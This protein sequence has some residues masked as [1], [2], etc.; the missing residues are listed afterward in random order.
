MNIKLLDAVKDFLL[1]KNK[2]KKRAFAI[3]MFLFVLT[4]AGA[5]FLLMEGR[6][7]G[8]PIPKKEYAQVFTLTSDKIS[9]NAGIAINL[10]PN[11]KVLKEE[12]Q[13][14]VEIIPEIKG[15]WIESGFPD[16]ILFKPDAQMK[17]GR[18][19]SVLMKIDGKTIGSD[20]LVVDDPK[21]LTVFPKK[22][23][24]IHENSEITVMFNRPMVPITTLDILESFDI[25]I[26]I[27]P[28]TIGKFKWIGTRTIQFI[29]KER[30]I[31]SSNYTVK[32]KPEFS[33]LDGLNIEGFE[34]NFKTRVLR[35]EGISD[36]LTVYNKPISINFNQPVDLEKTAK[37]IKLTNLTNNTQ[38][39]FVAGYGYDE[40]YNKETKKYDRVTN[41]SKIFIYNK[42]DQFGREK[43]WDFKDSYRVLISRAWPQE[44]NINLEESRESTIHVTDIISNVSAISGRSNFVTPSFFDPEGRLWV[45]FYED[46]DI[47]KSR[48]DA[49]RK[50]GMGYG[51]KCKENSDQ[52]PSLDRSDCEKET[53]LKKLYFTFD[54][55]KIKNYDVL[56]VNLNEIVNMGGL[57][58]NDSPI[59]KEANV[60]PDLKVIRTVPDEKVSGA[61]LSEFVICS[62]S[63][64]NAVGKEDAGSFIKIDPEYEFQYWR[65]PAL[66]PEQNWGYYVCKPG[67]FESRIGYRIMPETDYHVEIKIKDNF[68]RESMIKKNFRTGPIPEHYLNFFH[69][70]RNQNVTTPDKTKLTYAVENMD[71]VNMNICKVSAETMLDRMSGSELSY[72]RP[73]PNSMCL[74]SIDKK[75]EL[76]KK[77]WIKNYFKVDLK[78]YVSFPMGHFVLTFSNPNYREQ[79]G[80]KRVI[81][82]RTYLTITNMGVVEKNVETS[83]EKYYAG[84]NLTDAQK[85]DLK[86]IFWVTDMKTLDPIE[87]A[88][89]E[90]YARSQAVNNNALT[91]A[92]SYTTDARGISQ[93][94]VLNDFDGAI[95]T[96][97]SDSAVISSSYSNKFQY[98]S[99]A[100]QSQKIYAYTDRPIYKPLDEVNIKGLY[101]LGYDGNYE[102]EKGKVPVKIFDSKSQEIFS[103]ELEVNDF[104]TF[105]AKIVLDEK[106]PLG[107]YRI[108]AKGSSAYF[109]VEEYVPAPF[110]VD[111]AAD[112]E[113][114]ISKDTFNL[115]I[116]ASYYF[117]A[118]LDGGEVEYDI[119]SQNYYFDRYQDAYFN[120]GMPWYYCY[121]GCDYGSKFILRSKTSLDRAGKARISYNLDLEKIFKNDK[122]VKSKI[123]VVYITVK[124]R[125]G[126]SVSSQKS[127]IVHRGEYYLGLNSSEY[128]AG[129]NQKFDVMVKSVNTKG[130]A[131]QV[132]EITL[133]V[134]KVEWIQSKRQEVDGG[135]YNNWERKL[136]TVSE[137]KIDTD[138]SGNWKE[139]MALSDEGEYELSVS[140]KDPRNNTI[141]TSYNMYVYGEAQVD[142]R[143]GNDNTLEMITEK[144][145]LKV[146]DKGE[147]VIKSPYEKAKALIGVER[148]RIFD[149][150]IVDV[151][152]NLF[153]YKFDVAA[154]YA[155]N[156]FV[157]AVLV[158]G[159]P[160]VKFG[161]LDFQVDTEKKRLD[162]TAKPNKA[163]Y[164]PGEEVTIDFESKDSDG[165]PARTEFSVSVAD[166]SVLALKGNPKKNPVAF[167]YGGF[168]L[169]ISTSS[170]IKNIL[171]EVN[172]PGET[173]GGGG[174]GPE[175]LAKKKR[176]EFK[177]TAFWQAVVLT[178]ENGKAQVKFKLP[179]N[180]TSWQ[181][182]SVGITKDTKVGAGYG[183]FTSR[184][185]LMV[186]PLKPRF[187][188]PG[189]EFKVGAQIF[190]QTQSKQDLDVS[191]KS[192]TLA[193]G[194]DQSSKYVSL[195]PKESQTIY[196]N[197]IADAS[198]KDGKHTFTLLAKNSSYEDT[199]ENTIKI[200]K[201][202]TYEA[203][204]TS[205]YSSAAQVQE[206]AYLPENIVKDRGEMTV[207]TSAT[208][209]V[210]ISDA[211]NYL[212]SYPYGCSEQVASKL[213][214][215][216]IVKRGLNLKNIGDKFKLNNIEFDGNEYTVDEV[217]DIGL[218]RLYLNQKQDGSFGYYPDSRS[219][220]YL[221]LHVAST[222]KS[223]KDAGYAVNEDSMRRVFNYINSIVSFNTEL[224]KDRDFMILAY[225]TLSHLKEFGIVSGNLTGYI[226]NIYSDKKY[227]NE[228]IT[229]TSLATLASILSENQNI[230]AKNY[231]NDVFNIL[232]NRIDI[233]SR[234]AFLPSAKN[235]NWRYYETP[236]KDTALLIK[237]LVEDK[238]DN[239]I[240]DRLMRW[241][242]RSRSKDGAWGSTNNTL[243]VI[244]AFT[245]YINWQKENE[246]DFDLAVL[247][248][249]E[250]KGKFSYNPETVLN[251]DSVEI[252]VRDMKIGSIMSLLFEK[253]N[254]NNLDNN[255]YYDISLKYFLPINQ[256]PPR[257][258]GF[259]IE[260]EFYAQDDKEGKNPLSEAKVGDVIRGRIKLLVPAQRN[261]VS[262]EDFIPAGTELINFNL[263]TEDQ[264]LIVEDG[265]SIEDV[266]GSEEYY[267]W[268]YENDKKLRPDMVEYRN[269]RLF[270]FKENLP[271]GEY[272]YDY[273]LRIIV[274]GKFNHLPA[275]ASEMYFPENFGRTRGDYFTVK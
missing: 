187:A 256:I 170:N 43:L 223:L 21:V 35:Y 226:K 117:G 180:L 229:N 182:E 202:E 135:Y 98:G 110:K 204:A 270:L 273:Y 258:E 155:P 176:G 225:S 159:K 7:D 48:I 44:G 19:Y 27:A 249:G 111:M 259:T 263:A 95:I 220:V 3:I 91:K 22:D 227:L 70:Q 214:S 164:L 233:D 160:E 190:N 207:K 253:N 82:E 113:E 64:I 228:E 213:D 212:L 153:N 123:I 15:V 138:A 109:D 47:N 32:V 46:I 4:V 271:E 199:V 118:T 2:S 211:L 107:T 194:N 178:D 232:E 244:D 104:G 25:P 20:F 186:V 29:P 206:F 136:T 63:P 179:D 101:R 71:Y 122:N 133:K 142:V 34:T 65:D 120:F 68:S 130:K 84:A 51:E 144:N 42:K 175:D 248:D 177:D 183:E 90:L 221:T 50:T 11:I 79:W 235:I 57:K 6:R 157:T 56:K 243:A 116:S 146:G 266:M 8:I 9:Q 96:K 172:V 151:N 60:I 89:I 141:E 137:R 210:F 105:N 129:K 103:Q 208:L 81:Y 254:H 16:K 201:N 94:P 265:R 24:E 156:F 247:L 10:P 230:F 240:L 132:G 100:L 102:I 93:M 261:F 92:D 49:D 1:G 12:A 67:E 242:L 28:Q 80:E 154:E 88:R 152:Q 168:P 76:P 197:V 58:L 268:N 126:Q 203:T 163:E 125:N 40:V 114:Y 215:I 119:A 74:A 115:D 112:K 148:G 18:Y 39:E 73:T 72:T 174:G 241:I 217:V 26:E 218:A 134:S 245:D 188:I 54:S 99:T 83:G 252:P 189:D 139:A 145:S 185:D 17:I 55:S 198:K 143:V 192:D 86:N 147:I 30:L 33:S 37:E 255:F 13:K 69:Y 38:A 237:T 171:Y 52:P 234:G 239:E 272:E 128:F 219:D 124:N 181:M 150:K 216:S 166:L 222:L 193:L 78:D 106:S 31:R 250:E 191:F 53:D 275:V 269:D 41:Q 14:G 209:A 66:V 195:G 161:K 140:G 61:S 108:D 251:Q 62:N 224:Q 36:G 59:V 260:R 236:I 97:G 87:G 131:K 85:G 23:S 205:G 77:Y 127:F 169:T 167:F 121:E 75:L 158:S 149:Y 173:K 162:I 274:P 200:T 184:K 257:D 238:N 267:W 246:S 231:K 264:S 5:L 262:V 196:F 45:E 165:K